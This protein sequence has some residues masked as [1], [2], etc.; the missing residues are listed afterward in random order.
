MA[1]SGN[2]R[3]NRLYRALVETQLAIDVDSSMGPTVDPGLLTIGV[4]LAPDVDPRAVEE[5]IWAELARLQDG[6]VT[7]AEMA[8]AVKQTRAQFA[9]S[10]ESVTN[11]GYWLGFSEMVAS[12]GWFDSWLE[13]LAAVK[14][15]DV[16]RVAHTYFAPEKQTVGWYVPHADAAAGY[17]DPGGGGMSTARHS[18]PGPD[19]VTRVVL[20]NGLTVLVRENHA[21][22]VAVLQGRAAGRFRARPGAFARPGQLH[23]QP[24]HSW[25]RAIRLRPLQR[26]RGAGG[27]HPDS[28][29][30]PAPDRVWP[31]GAG[32]G[33]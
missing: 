32:R 31:D 3:S 25:Q 33:L 28:E 4:T 12:Q 11:Q 30:R 27:R 17:T 23:G 20:S 24:A 2:N 18:L 16:R 5:A 19:D 13:R 22:P 6:G 10:S 9:Y 7:E 1:A 21:A 26:D 8:K 15:D 14:G 29:R